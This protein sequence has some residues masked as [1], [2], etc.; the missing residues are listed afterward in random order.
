MSRHMSIYSAMKSV[1]LYGV[2]TWTLTK[3]LPK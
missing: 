3:F 1:F 2:E